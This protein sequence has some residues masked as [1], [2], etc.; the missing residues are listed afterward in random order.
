MVRGHGVP[1]GTLEDLCSLHPLHG[2]PGTIFAWCAEA[3]LAQS[4]ECGLGLVLDTV[5]AGL[6]LTR[7]VCWAVHRAPSALL[8]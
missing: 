4:P 6:V 2:S 1:R 7:G 5:S 8:A 3:A